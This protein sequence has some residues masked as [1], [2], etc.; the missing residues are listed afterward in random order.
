MKKPRKDYLYGLT[1]QIMPLL[2]PY[3]NGKVARVNVK[4]TEISLHSASEDMFGRILI[5]NVQ[6]RNMS[7]IWGSIVWLCAKQWLPIADFHFSVGHGEISKCE[8]VYGVC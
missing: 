8:I 7:K 4:F 1:I 6:A 3:R 5:E 2:F